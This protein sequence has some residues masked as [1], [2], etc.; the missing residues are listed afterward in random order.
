MNSIKLLRSVKFKCTIL[1]YFTFAETRDCSVKSDS[2]FS[3]Q[4]YTKFKMKYMYKKKKKNVV[5]LR[6]IM[7]VV[8]CTQSFIYQY[9]SH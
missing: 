2:F 9:L 7:T 1:V 8:D 5:T 6:S 4:K 3:I